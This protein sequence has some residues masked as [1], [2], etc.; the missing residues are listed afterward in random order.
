MRQAVAAPRRFAL[1]NGYRYIAVPVRRF[2]ASI[3]ALAL[4]LTGGPAAAQSAVDAARTRANE[5][6]QQLAQ[7]QSRL[8]ELE[9]EVA[10]LERRTA[11]TQERLAG[12]ED[13]VRQQAVNSYVA[14]GAGDSAVL[15]EHDLNRSARAAA[16]ARMVTGGTED[17]IDEYRMVREDLEIARNELRARRQEA[18]AALAVVRQ[19]HQ[20]AQAEL[21]RQVELQRRREEEERRRRAA[22]EARRAAAN[23][24]ARAPVRATPARATPQVLGSGRWICPVQGPRAFTNDWGAPRSGG[25]RHM[26]NDILSPRGTPVVAPV[27]GTV[28]HRNVRLGGLSFYLRGDDGITYFGTHLS[29]YGAGGRVS[30]GTVIGYVGDTGN[31][32]GTPHLHFEMHPGGGSPVNPYPT[33]RQYC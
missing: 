28:T 14:G 33:L 13:L 24:T 6:A 7:A 22:E 30:A 15:F 25:R 1:R 2:T 18:A 3:L 17:A 32:R 26:G 16:L 12:L 8:A 9:G 21:A 11:A 23:R 29:A 10:E 31:A 27:S 19:R 4:V 5:V 20:A